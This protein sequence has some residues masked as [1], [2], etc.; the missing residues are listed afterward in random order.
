MASKKFPESES[1]D[2]DEFEELEDDLGEVAEKE[3]VK[4]SNSGFNP[5]ARRRLEEYYERK[6]L[7]QSIEDDYLNDD[8]D[9]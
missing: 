4:K 1:S 2:D 5:E 6:F 9:E 7:E 3:L 8:E